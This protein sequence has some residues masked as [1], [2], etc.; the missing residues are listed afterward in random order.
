M[1]RGLRSHLSYANVISTLCLFF[2]LG[3]VAL[4]TIPSEDGTLNACYDKPTGALRLVNSSPSDCAADEH[5]VTWNQTGPPGP[6]GPSAAYHASQP[7]PGKTIDGDDNTLHAILS[8]DLPPGSYAISAKVGFSSHNG[9]GVHSIVGRCLLQA[10]SRGID[11]G[12][13]AFTDNGSFHHFDGGPYPR[14]AY[15]PLQ[16]T[17]QLFVPTT[18]LRLRCEAIGGADESLDVYDGELTA[19]RVGSI[20][21]S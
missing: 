1:R 14:D 19:I 20:E 6:P 3:G 5:G 15:V 16:G 4:A 18:A 10:G 21:G 11:G 8:L 12:H 7:P 13:V 17:L 2:L 9:P